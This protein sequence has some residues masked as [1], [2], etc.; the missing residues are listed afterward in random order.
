MKTKPKIFISFLSGIGLGSL[1]GKWKVLRYRI[2]ALRPKNT[3]LYALVNASEDAI[4]NINVDGLITGWNNSAFHMFGYSEQEAMGN[5][6]TLIIPKNKMEEHQDIIRKIRLGEKI[7]N[8]ETERRSRNGSILNF[9]IRVI[10]LRN[11]KGEIIGFSEILHDLQYKNEA[12]EKQAILAA[13]VSSSDDAIISKNLDGIIMSWNHAAE[14]MF[15]FSEKEAIGQSISIIIPSDKVDEE[16]EI[17]DTIKKGEKMEHIETTRKSK[18]GEILHLSITISP[19]KN[20]NGVIIGASKVA[21]DIT[22]RIEAEKQRVL[23]TQRLQELNMQKDEFMAM[24]S[25]ELKTPLTV[26]LANLQLLEMMVEEESKIQFVKKALNQ[27]HKLAQLVTNLL[28]VSK[29]Q[30]GMVQVEYTYFDFLQLMEDT[31]GNLLPAYIE[32]TLLFHAD[33]SKSYR[34]WADREKIEQ[35][36]VNLLTNAIKY[37]PPTNR[38]DIF[39]NRT[40]T[41]LFFKVSDEGVGIPEK[42]LSNIFL[43]F[44]RVSGTAASFSGSGIGLYISSEIIKAHNGKIWAESEL[45]KGADFYFSI[46]LGNNN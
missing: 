23:F 40:D 33:K 10:P 46:P 15:G 42:D 34:I 38:I 21:R 9:S 16:R 13:I 30:K 6:V 44:F 2:H 3:F 25:H 37:T 39:L 28:D 8:Y 11:K 36:V 7:E 27:S 12:Q 26:I 32:H 18:G 29:M 22:V 17:I 19:I 41:D 14:K 24:A 45:G 1:W 20:N 43:R 31:L 35:V 5:P 4:V